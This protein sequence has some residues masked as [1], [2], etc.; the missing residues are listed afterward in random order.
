MTDQTTTTTCCYAKNRPTGSR[1]V[2]LVLPG[3]DHALCGVW[4]GE[5]APDA[6]VTC[7]ACKDAAQPARPAPTVA[8]EVIAAAEA[9]LNAGPPLVHIQICDGHAHVL[10]PYN[11]LLI[12]IVRGIPGARWHKPG[13]AWIIPAALA[14]EAATRLRNAGAQVSSEIIP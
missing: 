14:D 5:R 2:H 9:A 3:D 12:T 11:R 13:K 10:M 1:T 8:D 4:A 7:P 6:A